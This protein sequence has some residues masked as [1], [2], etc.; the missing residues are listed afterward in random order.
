[1][2]DLMRE[3]LDLSRSQIEDLIDEWIL[4]E[5]DRQILKRRMCDGITYD[6]LSEEFKLSVQRVKMI[7]YEGKDKIYRH[8]P[9]GE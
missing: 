3:Q 2:R 1:M 5:R 4:S 6:L 8:L 9:K 7:V